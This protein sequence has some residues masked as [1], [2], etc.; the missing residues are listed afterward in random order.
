MVP[1]AREAPLAVKPPAAAKSVLP[2]APSPISNLTPPLTP[3]EEANCSYAPFAEPKIPI[4]GSVQAQIAPLWAAQLDGPSECPLTLNYRLGEDDKHIKYGQGAWSNVYSAVAVEDAL[5]LNASPPGTP[6]R[7]SSVS[8]P[9]LSP[10]SGN[11]TVY[12]VKVASRREAHPILCA[13][14]E[15]LTYLHRTSGGAAHI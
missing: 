13:E 3:V 11:T 12:A 2:S 10:L 7:G 6:T 5:S 9:R 1:L 4:L 14:A 8:S 15:I